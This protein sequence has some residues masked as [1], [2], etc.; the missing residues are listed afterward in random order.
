MWNHRSSAHP[1]PLPKKEKEKI[2]EGKKENKEGK[3]RDEIE[4][5]KTFMRDEIGAN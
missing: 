5:E 4:E 3:T 1:G 2:K